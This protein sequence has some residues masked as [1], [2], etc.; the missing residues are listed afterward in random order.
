MKKHILVTGG[1]GFIGSHLIHHLLKNKSNFI[2][3]VDA[4]TYAADPKRIQS[5]LP[6][7]RFRFIKADISRSKEWDRIFDRAYDVIVHLAAE[8]HV[9]RSIQ[10]AGRFLQTNVT[11]TF[12]LLEKM[13]KQQAAQKLVHVSTDEVYGTLQP[14]EA[15]FHE[16]SPLQ[17]NNPYAASKAASDL[18]VRA[19]EKTYQLPLVITRCSNN[20]GPYQHP[21][22]LIPKTIARALKN[23]EIPIY[24]DG[25]NERDWLFVKD[26]CR[27]IE[28]VIDRGKTGEIY[29][30]G[31]GRTK[32]NIEVAQTI[33]RLLGRSESLLHFVSDRQGHDRKYAMNHKKIT[34]T[35]G[36][37]PEVKF[38]DGIRRTVSWYLRHPHWLEE[39]A[40]DL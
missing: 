7:P 26:H 16:N 28:R 3:A 40:G 31:T 23:Q 13:R 17:A 38:E 24:G 18:F 37:R 19:Y 6:H 9:G 34:E 4:L 5:L 2:T 27:A 25:R 22:K 1:A 30:I 20:Y 15:P 12:W 8:T 35:L 39:R 32:S 11:G 21:E 10:H 14:G 33:L 29:N 36:W